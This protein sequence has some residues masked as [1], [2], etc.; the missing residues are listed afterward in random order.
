MNLINLRGGNDFQEDTW[1]ALKLK[2]EMY[3]S[4]KLIVEENFTATN[5]DFIKKYKEIELDYINKSVKN[6]RE[7]RHSGETMP[8][9]FDAD[10]EFR[11]YVCEEAE[12]IETTEIS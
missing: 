8:I 9:Y 11:K 1:P 5:T 10:D 3:K 12:K 6:A 4:I 7:R 2:K